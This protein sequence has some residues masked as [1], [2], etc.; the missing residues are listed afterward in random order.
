MKSR[1]AIVA[2][3]AVAVCPSLGYGAEHA[4][5][6]QG[7]WFDLIFYVINFALFLWIARRFAGPLI[8][9]Y[10]KDRAAGI[11]GTM[12]RAETALTDAQN[13]ATRAAERMAQLDAEKKQIASEFAAETQYQIGRIQELARETVARIER[14]TNLTVIA[15][16]EGA[17][18]RLRQSLA[19]AAGRLARDLVARHFEASD[20]KRLLEVFI[21]RLG[22]EASR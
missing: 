3:L 10:F 22:D 9:G 21:D 16:R 7:S 19:M 15:V 5:E 12:S 8:L 13:L 11:R 20:Q 18:R 6:S 14:D 2:I 17:Q 4:A 1:F